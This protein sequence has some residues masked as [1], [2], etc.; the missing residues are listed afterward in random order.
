MML[1]DWL[2]V[3][4]VLFC[5]FLAFFFS[6][7]ETAM[8]ASSRGTMLQ[9]AKDGN[10]DASIVT[11]LLENRQRLIG[12]LLIGNNVATIVSSALATALL[13]EWFGDIGV[14][15]ASVA[16]TVLVILFCEM[17]PNTPDRY[18][19]S[20]ARP[21]DRVIRILG[22]VLDAAEWLVRRMLAI[23]GIVPGA[24]EPLLPGHE[25][26]RGAVDLLHQEGSFEK[27]DRDML[28]GLL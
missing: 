7:S 6:G 16:M 26:L 17:L 27:H 11:R 23:A 14:L 12:A 18:A 13:Q 21:L 15:Y 28:G 22:P 8:T 10:R 9:L 5:L 19:I 2:I 3:V 25:R 20:I 4:A 1:S 24:G